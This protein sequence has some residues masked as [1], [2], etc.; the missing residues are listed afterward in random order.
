M[1]ARQAGGHDASEAG[2]DV[3]EAQLAAVEAFNADEVPHVVPLNS[4]PLQAVSQ[5]QALLP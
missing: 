1:V 4:V 2:P 3:L 5:I